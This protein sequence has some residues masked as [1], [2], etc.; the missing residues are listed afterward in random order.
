VAA[1][2]KR[3]SFAGIR[4]VTLAEGEISELHVGLKGT[5]NALFLKDLA[6][7]THRGLQGRVE[8]GRSG[9]GNSYGYDVVKRIGDDG[10][11]VRGERRINPQQAAIVRRIFQEYAGGSSPKAIAR[12]LN[13]EKVPGPRGRDWAASTIHGQRRRGNGIL[14]NELYIGRIV[15]NRLRFIKDPETGRRVAR[16]NPESARVIRDV[17][18]LRIIDQALWD[19]VKARQGA[20]EARILGDGVRI[21]DRRRPRYLFSGLLKCGLCGGGFVKYSHDRLGCATARTKGT[22]NNLLTIKRPFV[23]AC[24]LNGLR[25]HL[26]S[27]SV[28][29]VFCEEY[30]RHV[31]ELRVERSAASQGY[32]SELDK[33]SRDQDRLV[34]AILDGVPGSRVKDRMGEL[35]ARKAELEA[36]LAEAKE[37]P[38]LLHPHLSQIYR[39]Q[40]ARLVEALNDEHHRTEAAEIIRGMVDRIMLTPTQENGKKPSRS[41]CVARWQ[42]Y[43][44]SP[45]TARGRCRTAASRFGK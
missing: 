3:L 4:I 25:E 35:E 10:E 12:A 2:Y 13:G 43:F 19:K 44:R 17:R 8:A 28:Y 41:S 30:T 15:W 29:E 40:V 22:C 1:L 38:V 6:Q 23:E 7:K 37:E 5:M 45:Q 18:E 27:P 24:V 34:Q 31:N 33:V 21:E 26:M 32:R 42:A 39:Q 20:M 14:N 16:F 9:G 36:L 11:P